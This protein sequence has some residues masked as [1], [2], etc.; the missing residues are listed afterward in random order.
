VT[1][2]YHCTPTEL[3]VDH[4]AL[5]LDDDVRAELWAWLAE[6]GVDVETLVP[7]RPIVQ[8]RLAASLTWSRYDD[9][10]FPERFTHFSAHRS[11]SWPAPFPWCFEREGERPYYRVEDERPGQR[12]V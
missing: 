4:R 5:D 7:G 6:H 1:R 11:G 3:T 10:G 8:D 12:P 9:R 2:L